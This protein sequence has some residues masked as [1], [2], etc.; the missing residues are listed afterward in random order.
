M[1]GFEFDFPDDILGDV[2]SMIDD[3]APAMINE[4]LPIYENAIKNELEPHRDTGAL[5]ASIRCKKAK[6]TSTDAYVGYLT[7][8]GEKED[9]FRNYQKALA[10]EYGNS[11]EAARPFMQS[12]ANSS[13]KSVLDKMQEVFD[14][15]FR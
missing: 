5:I 8:V 1:A 7:A 14:R 4:A 11:H 2:S 13:E 10:I 3:V 12:A 15:R 6:K 9:G